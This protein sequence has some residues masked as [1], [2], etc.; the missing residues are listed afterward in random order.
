M[1]VMEDAERLR[2]DTRDA[3]GAARV[4][5]VCCRALR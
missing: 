3:A 5:G 4:S 1:I 2:R